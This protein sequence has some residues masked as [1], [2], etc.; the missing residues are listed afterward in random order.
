MRAAPQCECLLFKF[1]LGS[2][3]IHIHSKALNCLKELLA[4]SFIEISFL[5]C[6]MPDGYSMRFRTAECIRM[7]QNFTTCCSTEPILYVVIHV[8]TYQFY[9]YKSRTFLIV[10][11]EANIPKSTVDHLVYDHLRYS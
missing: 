9:V 7:I 3:N 5:P 2:T 11:P 6:P 8:Y 10:V 1:E 4:D